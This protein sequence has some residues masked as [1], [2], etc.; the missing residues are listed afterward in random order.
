[1]SFLLL[2][3]DKKNYSTFSKISR[4]SNSICSTIKLKK[5]KKTI[6]VLWNVVLWFNAATKESIYKNKKSTTRTW[7]WNHRV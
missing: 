6:E 5:K 4:Q 3:K 2:I 7:V 1:M